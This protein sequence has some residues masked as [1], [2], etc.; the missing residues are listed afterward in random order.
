MTHPLNKK[1]GV[2]C[3]IAVLLFTYIPQANADEKGDLAGQ[4]APLYGTY[5]LFS[6]SS[7]TVIVEIESPS[8]VEAKHMGISQ[9]REYLASKRRHVITHIQEAIPKAQVRTEYEYL[10]SGMAVT[11][12]ANTI[13]QLLVTPGVRAVYPNVTYTVDMDLD[14]GLIYEYDPEVMDAPS[15]RGLDRVRDEWGYTGKDVKVAVVDTGVDYTHPDL[16]NAFDEYKG[17]DF[18]DNNDDPQET[19]VGNPGGE[20]TTHGTHIAGII[21][22]DGALSGIAPEVTLLAYRVI[23]PGGAGTTERVLAALDRA[24]QDEA[25]IINLSL[26]GAEPDWALGKALHWAQAE[27]TFVVTS[28]E[29]SAPVDPATL[30]T[31]TAYVPIKVGSVPLSLIEYEADIVFSDYVYLNN[32][33][34]VGYSSDEDVNKL[35]NKQYDIEYVAFKELEDIKKLNIKGKIA[36]MN[37]QQVPYIDYIEA[38]KEAGAAAVI[39]YMTEKGEVP[40]L[41]IP[42]LPLPTFAISYEQAYAVYQA[43]KDG[44]DKISIDMKLINLADHAVMENDEQEDKADQADLLAPGQ[45]ILSTISTHQ[46]EYPHGYAVTDGAQNSAAHV[47][48]ALALLLEAQEDLRDSLTVDELQDLLRATAIQTDRL[49]YDSGLHQDMS[50]G[51]NEPG[52]LNLWQALKKLQEHVDKDEDIKADE[53]AGQQREASTASTEQSFFSLERKGPRL[54]ELKL[55]LENDADLVQFWIFSDEHQFMGSIGTYVGVSDKVKLEH[56]NG[57]INQQP[58]E[59]GEYYLIAYVEQGGQSEFVYGGTFTYS[60][61]H[62]TWALSGVDD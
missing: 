43:L 61:E 62:M 8:L 18:V 6:P 37:D 45:R 19:T 53:D 42:G 11:L 41:V 46:L 24:V 20:P 50:T 31:E 3:L 32:I 15:L 49:E 2:L 17:W 30:A 29:M 48:G 12:P 5:D 26:A 59:E 1:W 16:K 7:V 54:F 27:N 60:Q 51:E 56:W 28:V 23:G 36:I 14:K 47:A 44:E 21:A 55:E 9:T 34:V 10:F 25:D 38:L 57:V 40:S 39:I 13:P 33:D 52:R 35:A 58:L 4:L 22:A